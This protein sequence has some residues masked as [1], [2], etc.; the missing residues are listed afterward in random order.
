MNNYIYII[1]SADDAMFYLNNYNKLKP[2]IIIVS[3]KLYEFAKY[4]FRK[5]KILKIYSIN[6]N[7]EKIKL[8]KLF[9]KNS[10]KLIW[11]FI[12]VL[13]FLIYLKLFKSNNVIVF[14]HCYSPH[15]MQ[16]V[17]FCEKIN[18]KSIQKIISDHKSQN[19]KYLEYKNIFTKFYGWILFSNL[20]CFQNPRFYPPEVFTLQVKSKKF[21]NYKSRVDINEYFSQN[22][23]LKLNENKKNILI[24]DAPLSRINFLYTKINYSKTINNF[25]NFFKDLE[26]KNFNIFFKKRFDISFYD[27]NYVCDKI[28]GINFLEI[29]KFIP[30]EILVEKFDEIY[31]VFSFNIVNNNKKILNLSNLIVNEKQSEHF[32]RVVNLK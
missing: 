23:I 32:N 26:N 10:L 18:F 5:S 13:P 30:A 20:I 31:S 25:Q 3:S 6:L 17:A 4:N 24:F 15:V 22:P 8:P 2:S 16:L 7:L 11:N 29:N 1:D 9:I 19:N 21:E 14:S 27:G 12:N 28:R